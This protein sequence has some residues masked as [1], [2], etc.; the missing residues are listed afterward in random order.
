MASLES[1]CRNLCPRI[2]RARVL[3]CHSPTKK[4][5]RENG[6]KFVIQSVRQ[7]A[8]N[9]LDQMTGSEMQISDR[10]TFWNDCN[11]SLVKCKLNLFVLVVVV[12]GFHCR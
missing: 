4:N 7:V 8:D 5:P 2:V 11:I 10:K 3:V 1:A 6:Q 9:L 12:T